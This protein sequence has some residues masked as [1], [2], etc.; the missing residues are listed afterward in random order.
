MAKKN[1]LIIG[2]DFD[3]TVVTHEFPKI[4]T[5]LADA[6]EWMKTLDKAGAKLV[7]NT[8]RSGKELDD[9]VKW[10]ERRNIPLYG[11]NENPDQKNWTKSPKVYAHVYVDDAAVGCPCV[12]PSDGSKKYVDWSKVG[13]ILMDMIND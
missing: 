10:F 2:V 3:G 7:L 12:S 8:M 4:G 9:A 6:V 13:P 5:A 11:V 1:D